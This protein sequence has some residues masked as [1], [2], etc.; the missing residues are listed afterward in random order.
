M[1]RIALAPNMT[2]TAVSARAC[3]SAVRSASVVP[4]AWHATAAAADAHAA[5]YAKSS[6]RTAQEAFR[7]PT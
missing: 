2:A 6:K 1:N 7:L 3:A 4:G 5:K